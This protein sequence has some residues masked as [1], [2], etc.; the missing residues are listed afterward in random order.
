MTTSG[1]TLYGIYE[2]LL[3]TKILI[4]NYAVFA[5]SADAVTETAIK[6]IIYFML[7]NLVILIITHLLN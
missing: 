2:L 7:I 5:Y 3:G 1:M 4:S 6:I